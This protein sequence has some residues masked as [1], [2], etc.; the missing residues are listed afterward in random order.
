MIIS[1]K[2]QLWTIQTKEAWEYAKKSGVLDC[3]R[4]AK[5]EIDE[6]Y[7]P[8]YDWMSTQLEKRIKDYPYDKYPIWGWSYPKPDLRL[9]GHLPRGTQGVRIEFLVD[10][11]KVL[12]SSFEAWHFVLNCWYLSLSEEES[13]NWDKRVEKAEIKIDW[14]NWP[15]REPF[16]E[17]ILKSWERIFDLKLLKHSNWVGCQD[18]QACVEKIDIKEII[19][20]T[21]FRAK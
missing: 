5:R 16:W 1:N 21:E 2:T 9:G 13:N 17:E 3:N 18:I 19:N 4:V 10:Y 7:Y 11:D 20:V 15:P 12:L 8:A 14:K 6:Y